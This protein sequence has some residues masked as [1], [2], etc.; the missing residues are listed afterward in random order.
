MKFENKLSKWRRSE[1]KGFFSIQRKCIAKF[2]IKEYLKL[3]NR[4]YDITWFGSFFGLPS[5]TMAAL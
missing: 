1:K 2:L 3:L 4:L 5:K